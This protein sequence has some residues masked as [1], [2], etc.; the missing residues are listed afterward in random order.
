VPTDASPPQSHAFRAEVD[1]L[2]RLV[3]GSLYTNA[4]VFLRELVSNAADAIDKARFEALLHPELLPA[5]REVPRITLTADA[6]R[7]VLVI[8]DDGIGMSEEEAIQN[9]GTIA[10]SGTRA[11]LEAASK[12]QAEGKK[13]DLSLIGQFGVGFYSAFMVADRI[14]VTSLSARPGTP[15]V[16]WSSTG[17]GSFTTAPAAREHRGTTIE[18]HLRD[19]AKEYLERL[20]LEHLVRR[21]SNFVM[22]PIVLQTVADDGTPSEGEPRQIN[23]ASAFWARPARD[24]TEQDYATFYRHVMG[25]FVL[26]GDEPLAHLHAQLEAPIQFHALLYVPGHAPADLFAEDRKALALYAK[27]V[28]VMDSTDALLPTYL[29]FFRGVVDSEDLPLNVSREMLQEHK[30]LAA[31][32][33]QLTRKALKLLEDLAESDAER[34]AKLWREYG[35]VIKEGIHTDNAQRESLTTLLRYPTL[36]TVAE[37]AAGEPPALRSLA[38][39]VE[40]MPAAQP[41]IFFLTG[42]DAA[43]LAR[44]PH[45]EAIRARGYDVLLMTDA[46]D[47]WVVQDLRQ[48]Q[49]KPLR[50][51]TKG[52]LELD[53]EAKDA[54]DPAD[55]GGISAALAGAREVLGERVAAVRPSKRLEGSAAC[56]VDAEGGLGR[57]MER[58]LAQMGRSLP[59][60]PR[61]LELNPKHPFVQALERVAKEQPQDPR[62]AQWTELLLDQAHLAEGAVPDPAAMVARMQRVLDQVAALD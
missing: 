60:S 59:S 48:F 4:E 33:R 44:S 26:P 38:Q 11:F 55:D 16:R 54:G 23:E 29:R 5:P 53:G 18:L 42:Q 19:D 58:L 7:G 8:E 25:G 61:V 32:R 14:E 30:S 12:A 56:L 39:Y 47:E 22:H 20:R 35:A 43:T 3:T 1:A 31:I 46:V 41:A 36:T 21:Y 13:P 10:H 40:A 17:D 27:R 28:L 51:A 24:L 9:L 6:A 34:Y 62:V 2:L 49:G 52:E 57:N 50:S 37:A 15:A 45:V